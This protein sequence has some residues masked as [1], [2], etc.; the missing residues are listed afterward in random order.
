ME[1]Q[2][3]GPW[4]LPE[5]ESGEGQHNPF[6]G[7]LAFLR[8]RKNSFTGEAL[9]G[10]LPAMKNIATVI[11]LAVLVTTGLKVAVGASGMASTGGGLLMLVLGMWI[12]AARSK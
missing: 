8:G 2:P 6:G 7:G 1:F 10:C 11:T 3:A 5:S 12:L 9:E 4:K